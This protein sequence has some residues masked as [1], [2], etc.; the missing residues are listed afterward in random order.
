MTQSIGCAL[1]LYYRL[2]VAYIMYSRCHQLDTVNVCGH[3]LS[4]DYRRRAA[5]ENINTNKAEALSRALKS[6]ACGIDGT[7]NSAEW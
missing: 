6:S 2:S 7:V 1:L 5:L 3:R 4:I